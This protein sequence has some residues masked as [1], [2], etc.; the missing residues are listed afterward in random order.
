VN[1]PSVRVAGLLGL[2]LGAAGC[3]AK[4][5]SGPQIFSIDPPPMVSTKAAPGAYAVAVDRVE[6]APEF[7]GRALSYRSGAHSFEKDPYAVLAASPRDLVLAL[8]RASLS[9]MDF[10]R[11]MVELGGPLPADL[12]VEAYVSDLEGDFTVQDKPMAA[13]GVELVVL[14]V[15]PLPEP[16]RPLL[17]K[18]YVR[19]LP[20]SEKSATAVANAWNEGL[21]SIVQEFLQDMRAVL[22]ATPVPTH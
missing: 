17:R 8:L 14:S 13:V 5:P 2:A 18:A 16:V 20:L 3:L 4:P 21:N 12:L 11:E 7:A 19:R 10:V 6:V 15:P 1:R 9:N 22:P